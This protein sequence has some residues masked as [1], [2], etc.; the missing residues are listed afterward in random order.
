M[1]DS[2]TAID[3]TAELRTVLANT[4]D[5]AERFDR[6]DIT[7]ERVELE[8]D[9]SSFEHLQ[10]TRG[11]A[12]AG[13]TNDAGDVLL[14]KHTDPENTHDWVLPHGPVEDGDDW[15]DVAADWVD[16][17]T[18]ISVDIED[19]VHVRQNKITHESENG[20]NRKTT[21]YHVVFS[22]RPEGETEIRKDVRYDCDDEWVADWHGSIP[23][24]VRD[25]EGQ[26][27]A[28]FLE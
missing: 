20:E 10:S 4:D 13:V 18:G 28:R 24:S 23:D 7:T 15:A 14:V 21:T 8:V 12:I 25:T 11:L 17:L 22:G 2:S 27:I 5:P 3:D 6:D 16:G 19:I 26:D 1:T 9:E